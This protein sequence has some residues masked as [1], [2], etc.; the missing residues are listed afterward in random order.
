MV[1]EQNRQVELLPSSL[2][3]SSNKFV[4]YRVF[5]FWQIPTTVMALAG[6]HLY[7]LTFHRGC[8]LFDKA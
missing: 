2:Y 4:E 1:S 8:V 7:S 3:I 5:L 6:S